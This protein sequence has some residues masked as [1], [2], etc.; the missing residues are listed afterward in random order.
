MFLAIRF[1][2]L[3]SVFYKKRRLLKFS[4]VRLFRT[5]GIVMWYPEILNA[6]STYIIKHPEKEV[7]LCSALLEE[8]IENANSSAIDEQVTKIIIIIPGDF[9]TFFKLSPTVCTDTVNTDVF[10]VSI[11]VGTAYAS[12]YIIV[13]T[14]INI[15]GKKQMMYGFLIISTLVG[16]VAQNVHGYTAIQISI[17]IF[18]MGGAAIGVVNAIVVDLFPTEIRAMALSLSLMCGRLG[19]V[20]GSNV[21]GPL[22][23]KACNFTF[24]TTALD[25]L[26]T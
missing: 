25:H 1:V 18:L 19:A 22:I 4:V 2:Y 26:S 13:G 12:C 8:N 5:T 16:I 20:T 23:Y 14:I 9:Q 21:I 24:Y 17:G 10:Y 3:V 11:I 6:M 15:V 7:T